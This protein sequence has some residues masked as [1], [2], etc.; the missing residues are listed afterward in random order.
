MSE[1][2][3][4]DS[5]KSSIKYWSVQSSNVMDELMVVSQ[6]GQ[7]LGCV[8]GAMPWTTALSRR[9]QPLQ[10]HLPST[11]TRSS[12]EFGHS[13]RLQMAF[14]PLEASNHFA[15]IGHIWSLEVQ[16]IV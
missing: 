5:K 7:P 15:D 6:E 16:L 12:P 4:T 1:A 2:G 3:K 9:R 8:S 13:C 10:M 14:K 11:I